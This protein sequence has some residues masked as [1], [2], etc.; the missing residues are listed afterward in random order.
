MNFMIRFYYNFSPLQRIKTLSVRFSHVLQLLML[1][2]SAFL[3][4]SCEE[5]M[6]SVGNELL[7]GSDYVKLYATDTLTVRS[8]TMY[9]THVPT[10]SPSTAIIG[11]IYDPY[12][13]TTTSEFVS[14]IRLGGGWLYGPVTVDSVKLYLNLLTVTGGSTEEAG[15]IRLSEISD[16][17]SSDSTYY[18]DT[19]TDTTDFSV[20]AQ[21][22]LLKADT[23]NSISVSLPIQLGEY[24]IRDTTKLFYKNENDDFRSWFKGLR[25]SIPNSADPLM[26]TFSTVSEI[27]SGG[28]YNNFIVLYMHDT[29]YV[30]YRYY[31][32]I[33]ALHPNTCYNRIIRDF[34]TADPDKKIQHI[35]DM[36][37]RDTLSYLQYLAGVYTKF[38]FPGLDSLKKELNK[39]KFS[40]N[41]ARITLPVYYDNSKFTPSTVP[42][43]LMLEYTGSK[44]V[45]YLIPDYG[46]GTVGEFFDGSLHAT[47]STY[48][49][50]IPTYIQN[51]MEDT[52]NNYPPEL[53]VIQTIN[54]LKSVIFK[55]NNAKAKVKF[56]L[57]YT[58]Y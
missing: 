34:S 37:Y 35:N 38:V 23:V 31:F 10:N 16:Q 55:A 7:P 39:G 41:K 24:L 51:Y 14:Q 48:Y 30:S 20:L 2:I 17:L 43:N 29:A 47:D 56:E 58:K 36:S 11:N 22:P 26:V 57:T 50:N 3:V 1:V 40:I 53:D 54:S 49:F 8:Y 25:F 5:G 15:Y 9:D 32:I 18:S 6:T 13:G 46:I 4:N 28:T 42:P 45:K 33:D 27:S 44:G 21:L 12:Y 52:G 19:Q